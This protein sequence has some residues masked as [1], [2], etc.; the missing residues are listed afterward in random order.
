ML[1]DQHILTIK[2]FNKIHSHAETYFLKSNF[3]PNTVG[4]T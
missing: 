2:L 3:K 4:S 1:T